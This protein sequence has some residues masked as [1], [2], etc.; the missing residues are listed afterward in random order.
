MNKK[1]IVS[2]V[3]PTYNCELTLLD[4][5]NS[6]DKQLTNYDIEVIVCDDSSK[7][8]TLKILN[9]FKP[10]KFRLT[11]MQNTSNK[12]A[13]FTRNQ[14]I[15]KSSGRYIMFCDA[16]DIW[17]E[18]KIHK[19]IEFM[20]NKEIPF[21]YTQYEKF[22]ND[23]N[24][25]KLIKPKSSVTY[26]EL[27]VFNHICCSTVCYD[28]SFFGKQ[29]MPDIRKRQDYATWLKM[30]KYVEKFYCLKLPL[31]HKKVGYDSISNNK[32]SLVS[33]NY[34]VLTKFE[35]IPAPIAVY[36][37]IRLSLKKII[38]IIFR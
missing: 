19:Q 24:S 2:V 38:D 27:L 31:M 6:I 37:L 34:K 18:N 28:T 5:L 23:I 36:Y 25:G 12:G 29:Y 15:K 16:D 21:S 7:D 9:S 3:I 13:A 32:L 22:S 35:K 8:S 20:K 11:I 26:K 1:E 10:K 4:T 17:R 14:A 30:I 33:Y